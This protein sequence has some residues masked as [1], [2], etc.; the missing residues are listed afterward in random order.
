MRR[1][2]FV[3]LL[4]GAALAVLT[5]SGIAYAIP[6]P[7]HGDV[8]HFDLNPG[9]GYDTLLPWPGTPASPNPVVGGKPPTYAGSFEG[10]EFVNFTDA[11][12]SDMLQMWENE[13]QNPTAITRTFKLLIRDENPAVLTRWLWVTLDPGWSIL[14]DFH[15]TEWRSEMGSFTWLAGSLLK[16]PINV[17]ASVTENKVQTPDPYPFPCNENVD[18]CMAVRFVDP[19]GN[20]LPPKDAIGG[21]YLQQYFSG[22]PDVFL[23]K[24]NSRHRL[25]RFWKLRCL[26]GML[27]VV[28]GDQV[29]PL[30]GTSAPPPK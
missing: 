15:V 25:G 19:V 12:P 13:I 5:G 23:L 9:G 20:V 28:F 4:L 27:A 24:V 8:V 7:T 3:A 17:D 22:C 18:G 26:D 29:I 30:N 10:G 21:R 16:Y 2:V 6:L 14:I 11:L 1:S